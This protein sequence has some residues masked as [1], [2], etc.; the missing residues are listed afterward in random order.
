MKLRCWKTERL[1]VNHWKHWA[2]Y[3]KILTGKPNA[4]SKENGKRL[5]KGGKKTETDYFWIVHLFIIKLTI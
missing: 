2:K 1:T 3:T 4:S 5:T